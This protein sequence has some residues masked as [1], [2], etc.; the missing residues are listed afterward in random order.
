MQKRV[1][2]GL[3]G[4][5]IAF[6]AMSA[7]F[8]MAAMNSG[9]TVDLKDASVGGSLTG[10]QIIPSQTAMKAGEIAFSVTNRSATLVHEMIVVKL[11][12]QGEMLPYDV[13]EDKVDEDRIKSLGE[14]S[15]LDPGKTGTLRVK[16]AP[17][18]YALLC[19]QRGH[20]HAGMVTA[21]TVTR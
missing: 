3:P 5:I 7:P 10:M 2:R 18:V 14:V 12:K 20:Y 17:G 8:A 11:D 4:Y 6:V 1:V 19:N 9:V 21:I 16:L 13:N 15:E